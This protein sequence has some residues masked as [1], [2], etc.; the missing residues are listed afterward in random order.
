MAKKRPVKPKRHK[1]KIGDVVKFKFA[2]SFH[3]GEVIELTKE[4]DGHATYTVTTSGNNMIY[5]CLG[6]NGSKET[7]YIIK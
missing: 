1:C 3:Y 7:G 4:K 5:P 2:G 6:L